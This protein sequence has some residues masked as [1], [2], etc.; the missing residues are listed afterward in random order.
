M[1]SD[2][3]NYLWVLPPL[4]LQG[5]IIQQKKI[6]M[7]RKRK[8]TSNNLVSITYTER[9]TDLFLEGDGGDIVKDRE[10]VGLDG[11]SVRGLA[12]YLQQGGV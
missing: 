8:L 12:E 3:V 4:L 10:E 9:L 5:C 7:Q 6:K 1:K 2:L 11:V